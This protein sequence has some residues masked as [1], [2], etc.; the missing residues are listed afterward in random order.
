MSTPAGPSRRDLLATG[1]AATA[2]PLTA[3]AQPAAPPAGNPVP[4]AGPDFS[5]KS[6]ALEPDRVVDSVCQFCNSCCRLKVHLKAG[7]VIDV[8]GEDKDPV[9]AGQLCVKGPMMAQLVY[10]RH[11]LRTPLR[12]TGKKG[13]P[14]AKFEP[15]TW[16]EALATI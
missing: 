9:Q 15:I 6:A 7:R 14:N 8:R 11:R 4:A 10:N 12:R 3:S 16:H 2:L 5:L 1:L 13:D